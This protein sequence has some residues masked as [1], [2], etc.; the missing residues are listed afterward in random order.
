MGQ[1]D[2]SPINRRNEHTV[3]NALNPLSTLEQFSRYTV[4][5]TGDAHP[6]RPS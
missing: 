6:A 4:S 1:G 3:G 2:V 5:L